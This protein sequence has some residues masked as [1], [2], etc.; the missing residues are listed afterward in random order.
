MTRE[1]IACI[2]QA[3]L[4][5]LEGP[6]CKS[7][8]VQHLNFGLHE[9]VQCSAQ[10]R[11]SAEHAKCSDFAQANEQQN[12]KCSSWHGA[13]Q[14]QVVQLQHSKAAATA[15]QEQLGEAQVH[16]SSMLL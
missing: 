11:D 8:S 3:A 10:T 12:C 7:L 16:L 9:S 14:A 1:L 13:V 15:A 6:C 5:V 4:R 2:A